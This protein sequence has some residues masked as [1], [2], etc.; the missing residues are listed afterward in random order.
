[1]RLQQA[2]AI[3]IRTDL[4]IQRIA[5]AVG[6][7]SVEGFTRAFSKEFILSPAQYRHRKHTGEYHFSDHNTVAMP[8]S[9][10][11]GE[12]V[13]MNTPTTTYPVDIEH[14]SGQTLVGIKHQ[15]DY[16]AI[17]SKFEQ[18]SAFAASYELM[19][20]G[21]RFFGIY[22]DDPE[23]VPTESLRSMACLTVAPD[24]VIPEPY[25]SILEKT[26]IPA[27]RCISLLFKGPYA[28]LEQPYQWLYSQWLPEHNYDIA[29]F[30]AFE[31]YLNEPRSTPPN[32]LL[33]MIRCLLVA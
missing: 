32:E 16:M 28:E 2:A 31:E 27:G 22:Y 21:P 29:D 4:S 11:N 18:L 19:A 1:L 17:G 33:T 14:F 8:F 13:T 15:G 12:I 23:S 25:Q 10:P 9:L 24:F 20:A 7:R 6:Y 26:E 3:L 5:T 30:P